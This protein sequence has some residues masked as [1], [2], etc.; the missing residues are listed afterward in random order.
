MVT[1]LV[2][3]TD[4]WL[5]MPLLGQGVRAPTHSLMPQTLP[6][7]QSPALSQVVGWLCLMRQLC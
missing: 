4:S 3:C 1:V 7:L 2:P 5:G 6:P